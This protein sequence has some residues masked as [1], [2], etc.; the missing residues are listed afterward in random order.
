LS[1]GLFTVEETLEHVEAALTHMTKLNI[2]TQLIVQKTMAYLHQNYAEQISLAQVAAYVGL[3]EQHLIR[4]FRTEVGITSIDYL[5][6][7]R[8]RQA[9]I[10]LEA[11]G[12][13]ITEVARKAGFSDG[14]YFAR[15]F[16]DEEGVSPSTYR[17]G[18][19]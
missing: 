8:I 13:S 18:K 3:S 17:S 14:S 19:R 4:S 5:R 6:R 9:K 12:A 15:V 2:E 10:L 16:R 7:Y 11:G 1:K